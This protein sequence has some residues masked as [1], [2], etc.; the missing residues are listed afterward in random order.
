MY[1]AVQAVSHVHAWDA[2]ERDAVAY[3][4]QPRGTAAVAE[5]QR[6][7]PQGPHLATQLRD[8]AGGAALMALALP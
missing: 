6:L 1:V 7:S 2:A 4:W 3:D 8:L 5:L